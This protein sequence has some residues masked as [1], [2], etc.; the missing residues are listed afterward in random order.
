MDLHG[1]SGFTQERLIKF[2]RVRQG[3]TY[4]DL[5]Y[6]EYIGKPFCPE[7]DE[8]PYPPEAAWLTYDGLHPSDQGCRILADL[9]ADVIE[10]MICDTN[11]TE[12]ERQA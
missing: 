2:K 9:F 6:P 12:K 1:L 3:T 11:Q 7:E 10:T 4:A 8:Y 5:P